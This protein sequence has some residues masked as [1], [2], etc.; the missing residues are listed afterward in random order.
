MRVS[1][2]SG[3]RRRDDEDGQ[4]RVPAA[5]ALPA[6]ARPQ[7]GPFADGYPPLSSAAARD[8]SCPRCAAA[9][10]AR[11]GAEAALVFAE[12]S[13]SDVGITASGERD[14]SIASPAA[15]SGRPQGGQ[16]EARAALPLRR[17]CS[18]P[19]YHARAENRATPSPRSLSTSAL[20]RSAQAARRAAP[21]APNS[22]AKGLHWAIPWMM[23]S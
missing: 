17:G 15:R 16:T 6:H 7:L 1:M 14:G 18:Q 10:R 4:V 23:T 11:L 13:Y 8:P 2:A 19:S 5:T 9:R 3:R 21:V 22:V 20:P 12:C